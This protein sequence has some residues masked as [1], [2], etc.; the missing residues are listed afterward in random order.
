MINMIFGL[1]FVHWLVVVSSIMSI[2]GSLVYIRDTAIG[3]TKPNRITWFLWALAPLIGTGAAITAHADLWATVRVF[4]AG[5]M[6]LI[7]FIVSFFNRQSFWKLSKFDYF[8]G[9][10]SLL[11]LV[12]WLVIDV[13]RIAILFAALADGFAA[14]PTIIKG[15]KYPETESGLTFL[16]G[17]IGVLIILPSIPVWNIENSAFQVYLLIANFLLFF[18]IYRKRIFRTNVLNTPQ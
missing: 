11:A 5:F 9:A 14:L 12:L 15:W 6:P 10:C 18:S 13:P 16:I 7:V 1:S 4:L 17:F 2:V 3:K 8:C